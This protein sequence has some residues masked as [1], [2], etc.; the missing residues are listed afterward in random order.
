MAPKKQPKQAAKA[1]AKAP[2][3]PRPA[4]PA[5]HHLHHYGSNKK[6]VP[7]YGFDGRLD[8][9]DKKLGGGANE[10]VAKVKD[11]S[12]P[13]AS[14]VGKLVESSAETTREVKIGGTRIVVRS[15]CHSLFS[16]CFRQFVSGA[17]QN[18][19][20]RVHLRFILEFRSFSS[21]DAS[22]SRQELPS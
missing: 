13:K 3:P 5:P 16:S 7:L 18:V 22:L 21:S 9:A 11:V 20:P 12:R 14:L 6:A 2:P 19:V 1:N 17:A 10:G 15:D 8:P 4:Q